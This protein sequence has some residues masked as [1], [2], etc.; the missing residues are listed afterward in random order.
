M[1]F[2]PKKRKPQ[3]ESSEKTIPYNKCIAKTHR[4]TNGN[5]N[6]GKSVFEHCQIV[7]KISKELVSRLPENVTK[8][9]LPKGYEL[10][11]GAHDI[12]KI[13]PTFQQKILRNITDYDQNTYSFLKDINPKHESNWGGH[14]GTSQICLEELI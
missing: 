8:K 12:G 4:T 1:R 9:L 3:N 2:P 10:I 6:A 14:A 13:S 5:I 7:A 11:V